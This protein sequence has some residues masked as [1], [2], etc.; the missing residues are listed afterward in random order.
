[1]QETGSYDTEHQEKIHRGLEE[2]EEI[3]ETLAWLDEIGASVPPTKPASPAREMTSPWNE[4][5]EDAP[6]P[7][8]EIRDQPPTLYQRGRSRFITQR[9]PPSNSSGGLDDELTEREAIEV[10]GKDRTSNASSTS[11]KLRSVHA[12]Q[13][14]VELGNQSSNITNSNEDRPNKQSTVSPLSSTTSSFPPP[15]SKHNVSEELRTT[16]RTKTPPFTRSS[17]FQS[18]APMYSPTPSPNACKLPNLDPWDPSVRHLLKDVGEDPGCRKNYPLPAFDVVAN[19]LVPNGEINTGD[20]N[21]QEVNL[22]TIHR[23]DGDDWNVHFVDRGNPF[24][25]SDEEFLVSRVIRESDFFKLRYKLKTG[26][27]DGHYFAR[28]VSRN[29]VIV[30]SNMIRQNFKDQLKNE[31]LG[32]SVLM[33]GF[34]SVSSASFRRK[35]PKTLRYL[36]DSLKTYIITGQTVIGDGTSPALTAMLAG[37]HENEAPEGRQGFAN[38]GPID[39]W[40]WL[41]TLFKEHGYVTMMAEDDPTVGAFNLRLNGFEEPPADHY[42]RPFWLALEDRQERDEAGLCSRSTFMVNYTLDYILS[43]FESYPDTLKFAFTFMSYLSHAHPNH[44][45]Y[46]DND[47]LR[48]LRLFVERGYHNNTL[49]VIF[50]DHGSRNDDVRNTMQGKLEE[51]L[52]W[53]SM[54][55]PA[56]LTKRY[57]DITSALE[58]NQHVISSPFDLHATLHHVLTYPND[59][60]GEKTQTLFKK[61]NNTRTCDEAGECTCDKLTRKSG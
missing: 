1:M 28:V 9:K 56:W 40:P 12:K 41:M 15:S 25:I 47:V 50:G 57:P 38:S 32:L 59:P 53:L 19:R 7:K 22:E 60:K 6:T 30:K 42:A 29:D 27:E 13:F 18:P 58:H 55:L 39:K 43:Y 14:G 20:I 10:A 16:R 5:R 33:L 2:N 8:S 36:K 37:L 21:F 24:N 44:L 31:G 52:P 34:D 51:R 3:Q 11:V 54:S 45:S 35:M 17:P 23:D 46:A 49:I 48:L 26:R 4:R 61:L